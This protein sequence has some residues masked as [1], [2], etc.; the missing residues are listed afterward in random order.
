MVT[1]NLLCP[2]YHCKPGASLIGIV[3]ETGK[4]DF[5]KT[6]LTID[7]TFVKEAEK[8]RNPDF[9]FR[10]SGNCAKNGCGQWSKEGSK[11]GLINK[12][13]DG[14]GNTETNLLPCPIRQKC[15]WFAQEAGLACAN[16]NEVMRKSES[17]Y[18]AEA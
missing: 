13:I 2:S 7:E 10:F 14:L 17:M 9:R 6:P 1:E 12:L 8:G 18:L 16:C 11:C 3:N 4:V 15:R 5:L